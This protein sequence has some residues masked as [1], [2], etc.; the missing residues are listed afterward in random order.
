M[1]QSLRNKPLTDSRSLRAILDG[2]LQNGLAHGE[3]FHLH[4]VLSGIQLPSESVKFDHGSRPLMIWGRESSK[5]WRNEG[6]D[7]R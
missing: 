4:L 1:K 6:E 5:H 2:F 7:R 3:H